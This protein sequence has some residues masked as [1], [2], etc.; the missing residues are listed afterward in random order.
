M[1]D[2][3]QN[4]ANANQ[5]SSACFH[6]GL[7]VPENT[8]FNVTIQ[9]EQQPMCCAGCEAVAKTIIESD[10]SDYYQYR[11]PTT[12][13]NPQELIPDQIKNNSIYDR[14]SIRNRYVKTTDDGTDEITL[15]LEG[16]TC[17][18]CAWLIEKQLAK[19]D[20]I[21]SIDVNYTS[22][23]AQLKWNQNQINLSQIL[24]LIRQIGYIAI[25]YEPRIQYKQQ[26]VQRSQ[27]IRRIGITGILAMQVMIISVALYFGHYTGMDESWKLF[28]QKLGLLFTLPIIVYSAQGFFKASLYQ[29]RSLQPGMDVPVCLGLSLAFIASLG[30]LISGSG[31]V[32]YDS[33]A[34]FVFLLL[35]ARYFMHS[36]ILAASH[37]IERLAANTPL[38]ASKLT[39]HSISAMA[40]TITAEELCPG[41]WVRVL[42]GN[43]IPADG[44][45][46]SGSSSVNQA[47]MSGESRPLKVTNNDQVLAGSVNVS[48]PLIIKV[49]ASGQNTVYSAIEKM[50]RQGL[51][52][53]GSDLPLIDL[54]ARWFVTAILI[55]A[56]AV[57]V[58]WWHSAPDQWLSITVAVLVVSC[59]CALSLS[60]PSAYAATTSKLIESG[61]MLTH[62]QAIER[63]TKITHVIFDKTGTLTSDTLEVSHVETFANLSKQQA[64]KIAASLEINSDHPLAKAIVR[65]NKDGLLKTTHWTNEN[66]SGISAIINSTQYFIGNANYILENTNLNPDEIQFDSGALLADEH[67]IIARFEFRQILRDGV[68]ELVD[69]FK[70]KNKPVIMLTGD[71]PAPANYL[72]GELG[73]T[74]VHSEYMPQDKLEFVNTMQSQQNASI[75][76]IGDGIN[77]SPVLA[78]ADVSI[79]V[80]G[81]S[82]L[83]VSGAD[84]VMANP[85]LKSVITLDKY[86]GK[87]SKIIRQNITWAVG[88]NLLAIPFAA[89]GLITPLFAAVGMSLSSII[90]VLNAQRLRSKV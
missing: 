87:T 59:P 76:M 71:R 38:M 18:A 11:D 33:I 36:S 52:Q 31:E 2:H 12:A 73:I 77:D 56:F 34:M 83:A 35:V 43:V 85:D 41:D 44:I 79:A 6:C 20:G 37:S 89:S 8:E 10:L 54:I 57:A 86:A 21:H 45:I 49:T 55:I 75:L 64:L 48:K 84:I 67:S 90:V 53:Q 42:A 28:F 29:L 16:L 65:E 80:A 78:A 69:Y 32:Y 46:Q 66:T 13:R 70:S 58:Y 39:E 17:V 15:I 72:A 51:A 25:P 9:G 3:N 1:I 4:L 50:T 5:Y 74:N 82:P 19:Q 23:I 81:A 68:H 27:Q 22:M 88:Y 14:E 63:L 61:L 40:E 60:V 24:T 7:D 62:S 47:M 30:T 26:L